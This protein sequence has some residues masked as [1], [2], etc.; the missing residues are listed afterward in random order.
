MSVAHSTSTLPRAEPAT[1]DIEGRVATTRFW[2]R[3]AFLRRSHPRTRRVSFQFLLGLL[4]YPSVI[5][6]SNN[7][8]RSSSDFREKT[9]AMPQVAV[10]TVTELSRRLKDLVEGNFPAAAVVGEIS[11]LK[12]APSG[13]VYLTL[14]DDTAQIRAVLWRR[15]AERIRF[16][17]HDGLEVVAIGPV[18]VYPPRGQYQL[19]IE[20]LIPQGMGPLELAFRQL[21][22]K[23]AAEG[24]FASERKR[25]LP[26][27]PRRIA[28][29]T[30]PAG[31]AVRDLLKVI[32]RR[33]RVA[34]LVIMPVAVQGDG[35]AR[36][37]AA[38]L[39]QVHCIPRVDVVVTGRGG[40]SLEDLWA[41][42]EEVVA[43]AIAACR[44]P[45]VCGVGHEVDVTIAD[46]VA[47]VRAATPSQAGEL[48]VPLVSEVRGELRRLSECLRSAL[49]ERAVRARLRVD[50]LASRTIF[51]RPFTALAR[52]AERL[53]ELTVRLRRAMQRRLSDER[54]LA[55]SLSR[56]LDAL[57]PLKVLG[58][59]YS[60]TRGAETGAIVR[61]A[62]EVTQGE[63]V[64]TIL[65]SGRLVS[66]VEQ[67]T[68]AER[69]TS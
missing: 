34:D 12:R 48:V 39:A 49:R 25:P 58:R 27:F 2:S 56:S 63:Q 38:A 68:P 15:T 41:F 22:Q 35:A 42:N 19:V 23:L 60:I 17:L 13:H 69:R 6:T 65:A 46:L 20:E 21:Q 45:V 54:K 5:R 11:N 9:V 10:L 33:W 36:E 61:S 26:R 62:A 37:I 24:L 57:S 29:V 7:F 55:D 18:E 66:R 53:D 4:R 3:S 31:A 32:R 52:Q 50:A 43:R 14:K 44:V 1:R 16:N 64:E 28:I 47:D 51:T 30:S 67:I 8:E 40:G 59:G